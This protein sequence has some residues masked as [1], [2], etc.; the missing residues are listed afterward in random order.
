[1][2]RKRLAGQPLAATAREPLRV[3]MRATTASRTAPRS[4]ASVCTSSMHS[5]PICVGD[6]QGGGWGREGGESG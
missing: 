5:K 4:S 1:M 6:A 3:R 2:I